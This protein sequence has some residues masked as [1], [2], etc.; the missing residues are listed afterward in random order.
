MTLRPFWF[1][2]EANGATVP[3]ELDHAIPLRV[4]HLIAENACAF[5]D[6]ERFAKEIE[7]SV[8]DVV[9]QDQTRTRVTNKFCADQ[10]SLGDAPWSGLL[11]ILDPNSNLRAVAQVIPQHRQ[12]FRGRNDQ[13]F[14]QA[15][16]HQRRQ[17][18]TDHRFV[19]NREQLL[20][21]DL[22]DRK[23]PAAG[24]ARKNDGLLHQETSKESRNSG[25]SK[26]FFLLPSRVP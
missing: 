26:N 20:A 22:G 2:F 8:K 12:I 15:A 13:D 14:A 1:F 23:E 16:E 10:K 7:F 3:V 21:D 18:V 9:A 4:P 17:W 25:I 6:C 5:L 11:R 24:A 19:V